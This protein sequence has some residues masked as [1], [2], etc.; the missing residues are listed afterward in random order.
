MRFLL[1]LAFLG[2]ASSAARAQDSVRLVV[3]AT[4]GV[5]ARPVAGAQ[6]VIDSVV[7]PNGRTD[8][9]GRWT[10]SVPA[11]NRRPSYARCRALAPGGTGC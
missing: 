2:I 10:G 5:D 6:I 9:H 7:V 11:G 1:R 8:E 3:Q 4:T